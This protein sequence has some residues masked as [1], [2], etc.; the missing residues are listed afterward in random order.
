M[1]DVK[2]KY[3]DVPELDVTRGDWIDLTCSEAVSL[4]Q[5]EFA[6]IPLGIAMQIPRG[7]EAIIVPRSSTFKK[8]GILQTNSIGVI[9][10][11]YNGDNDWWGMPVIAMRDT[12]ICKGDRIAQFRL[13][14]NQ[15]KI[16]FIKV[17][18]LG[19]K[20]RGGFG[21]TGSN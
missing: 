6:I 5:G 8:W 16:N 20:D 13:F 17:D 10:N 14:K 9:D 11:D 15:D 12:V 18:K 7:Y 19:N 3:N 2:V 21:S 1:I 4:K